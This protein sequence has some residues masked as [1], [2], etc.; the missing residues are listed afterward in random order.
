VV[1]VNALRTILF[2]GDTY[3][4]SVH[5]KRIT[6]VTPYPLPAGSEQQ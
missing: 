6:A 3:A 1:L 4:G 5:D 2:L